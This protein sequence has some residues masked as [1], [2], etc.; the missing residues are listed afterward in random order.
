MCWNCF[1]SPADTDGMD[2][3]G[4]KQWD[5]F[6]NKRLTEIIAFPLII[7]PFGCEN[8]NNRP[9]LLFEEIK[10]VNIKLK[11]ILPG[12]NNFLPSGSA[13]QNAYRLSV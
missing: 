9:R 11:P 5:I 8:K 13:E 1:L 2:G 6:L 4:M 7:A 10:Y 12:D 3:N